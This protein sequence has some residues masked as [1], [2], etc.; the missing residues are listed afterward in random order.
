MPLCGWS[1]QKKQEMGPAGLFTER[2]YPGK[3]E[4]TKVIWVWEFSEKINQGSAGMQEEAEEYRPKVAKGRVSV[5]LAWETP[6]R[7]GNWQTWS[8]V[9]AVDQDGDRGKGDGD[10]MAA[11]GWTEGQTKQ[12]GRGKPAG[13]VF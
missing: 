7:L 5:P 3:T 2:T 1:G 12:R 11:L 4:G 10:G 9:N 6:K 13:L 8:A